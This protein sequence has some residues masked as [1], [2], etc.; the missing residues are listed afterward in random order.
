[1]PLIMPFTKLNSRE[2][3]SGR[4][5]DRLSPT[6]NRQVYNIVQLYNIVYQYM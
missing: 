5:N 2:Y 3:P 6:E 1:M 4:L